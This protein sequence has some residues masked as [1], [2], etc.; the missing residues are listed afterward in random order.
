M[1]FPILIK[2]RFRVIDI[3]LNFIRID[4]IFW[5]NIRMV[6]IFSWTEITCGLATK[7]QKNK[8]HIIMIR[9]YV[10]HIIEFLYSSYSSI[11]CMTLN[12]RISYQNLSIFRAL[13]YRN[14]S[15][16]VSIVFTIYKCIVYKDLKGFRLVNIFCALQLRKMARNS[17]QSAS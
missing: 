9:V 8:G 7:L 14:C 15:T 2:Y 12:A 4:V 16:I 11:Q 6:V 3:F 13:Y 1:K 17:K 10:W 5:N